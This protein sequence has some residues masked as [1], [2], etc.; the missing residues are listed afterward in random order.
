MYKNTADRELLLQVFTYGSIII[1][2]YFPKLMVQYFRHLDYV[3]VYIEDI[4]ILQQEGKTGD[5][6]LDK[7][8]TVL[9]IILS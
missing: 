4:L 7:L 5:D 2:S 9:T 1:T 6:H 8:T 3:L